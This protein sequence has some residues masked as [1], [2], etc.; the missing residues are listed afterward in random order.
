MSMLLFAVG[1]LSLD[2]RLHGGITADVGFS[3][4]AEAE[5]DYYRHNTLAFEAITNS[6]EQSPDP[7]RFRSRRCRVPGRP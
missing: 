7:G 1:F 5:T 4:P 2:R 6:P 3:T